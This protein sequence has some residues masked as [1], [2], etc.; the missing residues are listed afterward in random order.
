MTV[1]VPCAMRNGR[2]LPLDRTRLDKW[3]AKH[4]EGDVFD[5]ILDDGT[6]TGSTPMARKFHALRDEYAELNGYSNVHAKVELKFLHGVWCQPDSIPVGRDGRVVE[7]H[8]EM[9]WFLSI[10][11]YTAEELSRLVR[12]SELVIQE[13]GL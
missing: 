4:K 10:R 5:M 8:G 6:S 12:G 3:K 1:V 9:L 7:Y 2:V 13:A 11:D